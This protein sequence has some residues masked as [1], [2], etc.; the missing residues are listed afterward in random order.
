MDNSNNNE[1]SAIEPLNLSNECKG[2][3]FKLVSNLMDEKGTITVNNNEYGS[4]HN[5]GTRVFVR[6]KGCNGKDLNKNGTC[7]T[8]NRMYRNSLNKMSY[9]KKKALDNEKEELNRLKKVSIFEMNLQ[10]AFI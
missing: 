2:I 3:N 6:M 7:E 4:I 5:N 8:C 10:Q 9:N 1:N